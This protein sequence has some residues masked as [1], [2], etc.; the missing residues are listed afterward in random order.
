MPYRETPDRNTKPEFGLILPRS[1]ESA[2]DANF[3]RGRMR[4]HGELPDKRAIE[5]TCG[6]GFR[7]NP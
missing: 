4:K 6:V 7:T 5:S 2:G 3:P 1:G